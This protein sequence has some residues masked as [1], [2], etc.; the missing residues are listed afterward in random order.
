MTRAHCIGLIFASFVASLSLAA[1]SSNSSTGGAGGNGATSS[2]GNGGAGG[3]AGDAEPAAMKGMVKAHNDARAAVMPPANPAIPPVS[4]SSQIESVAQAWANNC[5]FMHSMGQYGENLYAS[6]GLNPTPADVVTSWV[7]EVKDYDYASNTCSNVCG[8]Y[9]Q[10]VWRDS[11]HI[12]CAKADCTQNS[13]F[14]GGNWQLWVCNYDPPG[15]FVGQKP[16]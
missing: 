1:C 4:W 13:P 5:Q 16:Y 9:T 11:V 14:G 7:S 10:V 12:G 15:N 6:S 8:H 3:A 2:S